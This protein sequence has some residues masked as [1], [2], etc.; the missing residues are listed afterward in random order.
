[1]KLLL[2]L[3]V[4]SCI[5]EGNM[6][7]VVLFLKERTKERKKEFTSYLNRILVNSSENEVRFSTNI[8]RVF[9]NHLPY[10]SQCLLLATGQ[11]TFQSQ[12]SATTWHDD[13]KG[14][15]TFTETTMTGWDFVAFGQTVNSWQC[16]DNSSS[17]YLILK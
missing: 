8:G 2:L 3:L 15:L 11:C 4:F 6:S 12:F 17:N 5:R 10:N 7:F 16:L 13:T 14:T 9:E 1:M